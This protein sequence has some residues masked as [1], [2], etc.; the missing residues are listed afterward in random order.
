M[1]KRSLLGRLSRVFCEVSS[2]Y[3][4]SLTISK[5]IVL[6]N[7]GGGYVTFASIVIRYIRSET[8]ETNE[9]H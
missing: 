2:L 9:K 4:C 6:Y 8:K 5:S 3:G 1:R 7:A